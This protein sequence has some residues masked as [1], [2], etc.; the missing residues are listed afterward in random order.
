MEFLSKNNIF[1][2]IEKFVRRKTIQVVFVEIVMEFK[3]LRWENLTN[4]VI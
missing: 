2:L 1:F 4:F 3:K